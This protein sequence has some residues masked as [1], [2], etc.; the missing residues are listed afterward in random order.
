MIRLN[1]EL[2]MGGTISVGLPLKTF[3]LRSQF[4]PSSTW[5]TAILN[6]QLT[7]GIA[8]SDSFQNATLHFL[9]TLQ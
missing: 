2:Q 7:G 1:N 3:V 4:L 5:G 8:P 9:L 6:Q